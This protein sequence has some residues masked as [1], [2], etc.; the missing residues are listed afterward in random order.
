MP[1]SSIFANVRID[2]PKRAEAFVDALIVSEQVPKRKM[3]SHV[4]PPL[5]DYDAI[6]RLVAKREGFIHLK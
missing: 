4:K 3:T 6:R 1:T 5:T 2:D